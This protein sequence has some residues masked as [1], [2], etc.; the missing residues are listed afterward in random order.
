MTLRRHTLKKSI[1]KKTHDYIDDKGKQDKVK[2]KHADGHGNE[3]PHFWVH[4]FHD[5]ESFWK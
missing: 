4:W 1:K 3:R 2:S 5:L